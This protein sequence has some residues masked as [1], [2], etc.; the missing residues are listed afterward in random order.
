MKKFKT[1]RE[2]MLHAMVKTEMVD[3]VHQ[4][5]TE[6]MEYAPAKEA[7][8]EFFSAEGRKRIGGCN[9]WQQCFAIEKAL[10]FYRERAQSATAEMRREHEARME[11][12]MGS[13]VTEEDTADDNGDLHG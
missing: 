12:L 4:C 3:Y 13:Y 7:L 2:A 9:C 10:E 6:S 5:M 1:A 11:R 8:S